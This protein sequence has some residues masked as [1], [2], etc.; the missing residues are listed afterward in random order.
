[1]SV[2]GLEKITD[3]ILA[4]AR[5]RAEEILSR[6]E[7]ESDEIAKTYEARADE[8]RLR[9]SADAERRGEDMV[10][11]ARAAAAMKK[12]NLLLEQ[13][14]QLIDGVF[15]S[16]KDWVLSLSS[17]KYAELLAGLL[18]SAICELA[19]ADARNLEMYGEKADPIASY[20]VL[21]NKKDREA[22]GESVISLAKKKLQ[23]KVDAAR[24]EKL[25]LGKATSIDGGVIL[26]AGE[27]EFNCSLSMLFSQLQRELEAEVSEA[28]FAPRGQNA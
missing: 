27:V 7:A 6:A 2:N 5:A 28:L 19:E 18:A 11:R 1:M 13:R 24:L 26:S 14:S 12:R 9:L 25:S 10:S 3:K 20:E 17:E 21:L 23:G 4:D 16:A 15:A 22:V 8:I